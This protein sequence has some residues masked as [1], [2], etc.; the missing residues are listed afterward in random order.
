MERKARK[1]LDQKQREEQEFWKAQSEL[2]KDK[3]SLDINSTMKKDKVYHNTDVKRDKL[4]ATAET[5]KDK[6]YTNTEH[7]KDF[8]TTKSKRS[9]INNIN[10]PTKEKMQNSK[11]KSQDRIPPIYLANNEK[12]FFSMKEEFSTVNKLKENNNSRSAKKLTIMNQPNDMDYS[13]PKVG[14][15]LGGDKNE[16]ME[17]NS[18]ERYENLI[19]KMTAQNVFAQKLEDDLL[20]IQPR[21]YQNNPAPIKLSPFIEKK[22]KNKV[23]ENGKKKP[24]LPI[25]NMFIRKTGSMKSFNCVS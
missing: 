2:K 6:S 7:K 16:E 9:P 17:I 15:Y 12:E 3:S 1:E 25:E 4:F 20:E 22:S 21:N 5:K 11:S 14:R 24:K 10:V 13:P 23:F 19:K 18:V 8:D